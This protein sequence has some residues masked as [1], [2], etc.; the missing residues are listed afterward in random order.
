MRRLHDEDGL[1]APSR[2]RPRRRIRAVA[3]PSL[4][5]LLGAALVAFLMR[6]PVERAAGA[7]PEAVSPFGSISRADVVFRWA[8]PS[9]GA[10]VRVEVL[11]VRLAT[12]WR[13]EASAEG[14]LRPPAGVVSTWPLDDLFWMPRAVPA[15]APERPGDLA[16]FTLLP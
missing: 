10:P 16:A 5:F 1:T 12:I 8:L 3:F 4:V 15:G 11:D 13:S 2:G 7:A 6:S 9:D 14:S